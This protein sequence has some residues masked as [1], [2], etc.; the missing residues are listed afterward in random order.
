MAARFPSLFVFVLRMNLALSSPLFS[1]E[2]LTGHWD[3]KLI[4]QGARLDASF[5][6]ISA[7]AESRGTFACLTRQVMYP[8]L[9]NT[10]RKFPPLE[11]VP[12]GSPVTVRGYHR[13]PVLSTT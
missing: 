3:G 5:D 6:F 4:R 10:A 13:V 11:L 2:K 7:G 12:T 9:G 8:S 1:D